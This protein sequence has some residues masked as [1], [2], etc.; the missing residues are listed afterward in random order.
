M[1]SKTAR[2]RGWRRRSAHSVLKVVSIDDDGMRPRHFCRVVSEATHAPFTGLNR[3]KAAVLELAILVSRLAMLPREKIE[4]EIAYL[5]IAI[6]KTAGPD[7]HGGLG[8]A[9]GKGQGSPG[10]SGC[11]RQGSRASSWSDLGR[12]GFW[13]KRTSLSVILGLDPRTHWDVKIAALR[14]M[15]RDKGLAGLR[16]SLV[17]QVL[18]QRDG[19]CRRCLA[20]VVASIPD[21]RN[22][23][24]EIDVRAI[25]AFRQLHDLRPPDARS[26]DRRSVI[27]LARNAK[28]PIVDHAQLMFAEPAR[29]IEPFV[30]FKVATVAP[31]HTRYALNGTRDGLWQPVRRRIFV[32]RLVQRAENAAEISS[33]GK[34]FVHQRRHV[35][36]HRYQCGDADQRG[37]GKTRI[38]QLTGQEPLGIGISVIDQHAI[39]ERKNVGGR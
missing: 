19:R 1:Q 22:Q 29:N 18:K 23:R 39:L 6:E 27:Q 15:R 2:C 36:A 11:E 31:D 3:A 12:F 14:K 5:T 28:S 26:Y 4:A 34:I 13:L 9:D 25:H 7:E 17:I 38:D 20:G 32:I 35:S 21:G 33:I 24:P 10:C 37:T 16:A 30:L 8:L